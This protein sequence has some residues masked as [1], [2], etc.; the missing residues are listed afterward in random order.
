V[1]KKT[2][3]VTGK[4]V[5]ARATLR[6]VRVSP[7]KARLILEMIKGQ[8]VEPAI[9]ML[10][11]N[12]TK[13]AALTLKLL[14]SAVANASEKGGVDVDGLWVTACWADMGKTLKRFRPRAQGRAT[15]IRKRS[16][17]ITIELGER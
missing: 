17:H 2:A 11:Y 9:Q 16:S 13:S 8:Q 4:D 10:Q 15:P 1:A 5:V 14:K 12:P 3:K 6:D 7:R